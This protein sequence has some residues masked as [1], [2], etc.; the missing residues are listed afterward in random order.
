MMTKTGVYG[1]RSLNCR[2]PEPGVH[3][4]KE[5]D[6]KARADHSLAVSKHLANNSAVLSAASSL[7]STITILIGLSSAGAAD[8]P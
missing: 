1:K 6:E 4:V 7:S 8:C 5:G 2:R 3:S